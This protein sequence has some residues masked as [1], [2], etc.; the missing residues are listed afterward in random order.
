MTGVQTCALPI[1]S[2][3]FR[4]WDTDFCGLH[5]HLSRKG[6]NNGSHTHRFLQLIYSN[7]E[8]VAKFGGRASCSYADFRDVWQFDNYGKPYRSYKQKIRQR[9]S[10][11]TAVNTCP[12][13][14]IE[15]RFFRGTLRKQSILAALDFA[16]AAVEYTRI[17]TAKDV[18]DGALSWDMFMLWVEDNNGIYPDLYVKGKDRKST[19]LN[20]S[21]IPLSRMPSSA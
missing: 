13:E 19:R 2:N 14:T 3:G 18:I 17:L 12:D 15:L 20:S 4:S 11:H 6:F 5:I 1:C 9:G 7:A 16:H 8:Q 10:R 21:H